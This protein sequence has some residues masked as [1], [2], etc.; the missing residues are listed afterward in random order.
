MTGVRERGIAIGVP[1]GAR[2]G[3]ISSKIGVNV[4]PWAK[5]AAAS[6][7]G[8]FRVDDGRGT[9]FLS[10]PQ[11]G[12]CMHV[13]SG[14]RRQLSRGGGALDWAVAERAPWFVQPLPIR[15]PPF[16]PYFTG[17]AIVVARTVG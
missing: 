4:E 16:F 5:G 14:A 13:H 2:S 7:A 17:A 15:S 10:G 3:V 8:P 6:F 12:V 9:G 1:G 11:A